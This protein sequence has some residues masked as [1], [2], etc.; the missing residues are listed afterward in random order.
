MMRLGLVDFDTSHAIEFTRRLNH[1][2][3]PEAQ[4]VDGASV[5]AACPGV[6]R[7]APERIPGFT[8]E[9]EAIGVPLAASP[10][11]LIGQV[12]G[13]LVCSLEGGVHLERARPFLEAGLPCFID[14]P[15]ACSVADARAIFALAARHGAP[16]FSSSAMRFAPGV[17]GLPRAGIR[18][19]VS[20]GPALHLTPADGPGNPG[21]FHYAIHAA[22]M[23]FTVMGPGCEAVS[24]LSTDGADAAT[25]RWRDGRLGTVRGIR[26]GAKEYGLLVFGEAGITHHPV[27]TEYAYRELLKAVVAFMASGEPP[28]SAEETLEL[29]AFLEAGSRGHC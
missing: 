1:A 21:L 2:G 23:L 3:L 24:C 12:D 28:V 25:G 29:I 16:V 22:E 20:H 18:G 7:M 13:V 14:K 17:V 10:R 11:D 4:W 6:S 8:A 15:L 26:D 19:V 5:V 27:S 9:L